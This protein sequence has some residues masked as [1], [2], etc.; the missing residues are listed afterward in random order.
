MEGMITG[1]IQEYADDDSIINS[2]QHGYIKERSLPGQPF[3]I[4]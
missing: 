3:N 2:Y 1:H 4:L